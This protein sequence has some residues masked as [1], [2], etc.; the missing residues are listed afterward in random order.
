MAR[1]YRSQVNQRYYDAYDI[2]GPNLGNYGENA[3]QLQRS[4]DIF[5]KGI[6]GAANR[7]KK[8]TEE[9]TQRKLTEKYNSL[10]GD[11]KKMLEFLESGED[12]ELSGFFRDKIV[13]QY[14]GR[15]TA[16][17][18]LKEIKKNMDLYDPENMTFSDYVKDYVPDFEQRSDDFIDGYNSIYQQEYEK[19]KAEDEKKRFERSELRKL[20]SGSKHLNNIIDI[21]DLKDAGKNFW[22][23]AENLGLKLP[24]VN[25]K[26]NYLFDND[27]KKVLAIQ[28]TTNILNTATTTEE[29]D[30]AIAVLT[31]D[32]GKRKGDGGALGSLV[33]TA[34]PTV[35]AL[36]GKLLAKKD[37]L[38]S[39][40]LRKKKEEIQ[41]KTLD[42]Y[43]RYF[44]AKD[45]PVALAAL[46][47]ELQKINP[48]EAQKWDRMI[49]ND[50]KIENRDAIE[51]IKS[52]IIDGKITTAAQITQRFD[53]EELSIS[54]HLNDTLT[55]FNNYKKY[56]G[57]HLQDV[58]YQEEIKELESSVKGS[59]G[60]T[61]LTGINKDKVPHLNRA[62]DYFK[63]SYYEELDRR[64]KEGIGWPI[65]EKMKFLRDLREEAF[66]IGTQEEGIP[67]SE[68]SLAIIRENI[69][70]ADPKKLAQSL[71]ALTK[72]SVTDISGADISKANLDQI[73]I[74]QQNKILA[75]DAVVDE[76]LAGIST[77]L[78]S[79]DFNPDLY[80]PYDEDRD[81]GGRDDKGNVF[82]RMGVGDNEDEFNAERNA[83]INKFINDAVPELVQ[84]FR[85][86][87]VSGDLKL[88][89]KQLET[90]LEDGISTEQWKVIT[91]RMGVSKR[92]IVR[93]IVGQLK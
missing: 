11:S 64:K 68:A 4:L 87:T 7:F 25:G 30:K 28:V 34:D 10:G 71:Q 6:Q 37:S 8:D 16:S 79:P 59:L 17:E 13:S 27:E 65:R 77:A 92:E 85:D 39:Q 74:D 14:K 1:E 43:D 19:L 23:E 70:G 42:I 50:N 9:D 69:P 46:R 32:R 24:A 20:N 75:I 38:Q 78:A 58:T 86:G 15:L 44:A 49:D 36:Y 53:D 47:D 12:K 40:E 54:I 55:F 56:G 18:S 52:D 5:A 63:N 91:D 57:A 29:I 67:L 51:R 48:L 26:A 41:L 93:A 81:A 76:T 35:N 22:N 45:D 2:G 31:T 3:R 88:N 61:A 62:L 72:V 21:S 84:V 73:K 82:Q 60:A 90:F 83:N 66:G 80:R 33:D 89:S